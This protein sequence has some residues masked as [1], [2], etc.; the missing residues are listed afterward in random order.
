MAIGLDGFPGGAASESARAG[1][2][3]VR[4]GDA[5][6]ALPARAPGTGA[7]R[8]A[9]S[10]SRLLKKSIALLE[11]QSEKVMAYFFGTLFARNPE[12]RAMFPVALADAGRGV[13]EALTRYA[14][15]SGRPEVLTGWLTELGRDHR[16][17]GVL[18]R[19]YR[20]FCDALL[21][22]LRAFSAGTWSPQ[23]QAAWERALR[24]M[25]V[26]M[27]GAGAAGEPAWWLAEVV[28]HDRRRPDLAVLTLRP[29]LPLPYRPGQHVS[30]QV[31]RWP[32][33]WREYS[34][35]N[36]PA[37]DGMLRLHVRAVPGGAVS[38]ALVH[39]SRAGDTVLLGRARGDMTADAISSRCVAC[40]AGGTGLAP[41]KAIAEALTSPLRPGTLPDVRVFFG[42]RTQA[43]LYDLPDLRRLAAARPSLSVVPVV[44]GEPGYA[45]L[46][47][48][49]PQ[50]AAAHLPSGT[51]DIVISGP[52]GL[53]ASAVAAVTTS[54][55]AAR[56]HL[57]PL[58]GGPAA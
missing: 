21:A 52:A 49:L 46:T 22:A 18:Q 40:V 45:G 36:A 34:V 25:A 14:W 31:P 4:A 38:T 58:P 1:S 42:A 24:R 6:A 26:A 35:A 10:D 13:F 41:V 50:A 7:D 5:G 37:P 8:T 9:Q 48:S 51:E 11:P 28:A 30:V 39:Q 55:P 47:G 12:L 27:A 23:A 16:K 17:F 32:R 43:D 2:N 20:P 19:H 56:I 44:T 29:D 15:C 57:D 53:V 54:A 3:D 33:V